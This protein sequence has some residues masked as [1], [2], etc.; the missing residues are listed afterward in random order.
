MHLKHQGEVDFLFPLE[1]PL[2]QVHHAKH[3]LVIVIHGLAYMNK[4][5]CKPGSVT[6]LVDLELYV[7]KRNK[8]FQIS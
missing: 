1:S 4:I 6:D 7:V 8:H 2:G 5:K 3:F